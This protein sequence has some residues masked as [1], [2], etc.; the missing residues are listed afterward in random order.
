MTEQQTIS[1]AKRLGIILESFLPPDATTQDAKDIA[2]ELFHQYADN[3]RKSRNAQRENN[4]ML[5]GITE[6]FNHHKSKGRRAQDTQACINAVGIA[7]SWNDKCTPGIVSRATAT[8][9]DTAR[10]WK[11]ESKRLVLSSQHIMMKPPPVRKDCIKPLIH[12]FLVSKVFA[13]EVA[14]DFVSLDKN[15][16][17]HSNCKIPANLHQ[18]DS[19][20]WAA[21]T[22]SVTRLQNIWPMLL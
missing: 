3:T 2:Q 7:L 1:E 12:H 16:S 9:M 6:F 14:G 10:K 11:A 18:D 4:T 15:Q 21:D 13:D 8:P 22:I 17:R 5:I 19:G 20:G